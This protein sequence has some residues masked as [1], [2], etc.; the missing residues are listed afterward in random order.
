M[1]GYDAGRKEI[2]YNSRLFPRV[3]QNLS[4]QR[5][6]TGGRKLPTLLLIYDAKDIYNADEFELFYQCLP[7]KSYQL[8]SKKC[9]EGN[10]SKTRITGMTAPNA[11]GDKLPMLVIGKA[12]NPRCFKNVK[13]L[14]RHYKNE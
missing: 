1:V 10:Q 7:N 4:H 5:Q 11:I 3:S 13:F 8:K 6:L 12:K 14:T 9:Y 2:I